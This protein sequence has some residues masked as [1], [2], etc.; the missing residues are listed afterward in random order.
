MDGWHGRA[1]RAGR[2]A[3]SL[4]ADVVQHGPAEPDSLSPA[5]AWPPRRT[6]AH[7]RPPPSRTVPDSRCRA[8][9]C[10]LPP[11][12]LTASP[13][14]LRLPPSL[15]TSVAS[16]G[17]PLLPVEMPASSSSSSRRARTLTSSVNSS[18]VRRVSVATSSLV[19]VPA[20]AAG[21]LGV[22]GSG[23]RSTL[24]CIWADQKAAPQGRKS[25]RQHPNSSNGPAPPA[26]A[27]RV[28]CLLAQPGLHQLPPQLQALGAYTEE[29]KGSSSRHRQHP[30]VAAQVGGVAAAAVAVAAVAAAAAAASIAVARRWIG[31]PCSCCGHRWA[32][33]ARLLAVPS[34]AAAHAACCRPLSGDQQ[35]MSRQQPIEMPPTLLGGSR[36][37]LPRGAAR[38][39]PHSD[40]WQTIDAPDEPRGTSDA[41]RCSI[42][43]ASGGGTAGGSWTV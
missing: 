32:L 36:G 33:G 19:A 11:P 3:G 31:A 12:P 2:A 40:C 37:R 7:I 29:A 9:C 38:Q 41:G 17:A 35:P 39:G 1:G 16:A 34:A 43:G 21:L 13:L 24:D 23:S 15:P 28:G 5:S 18:W 26:A 14:S 30:D 25:R 10:W 20:A 42:G 4:S 8:C 22:C 6:C 27:A